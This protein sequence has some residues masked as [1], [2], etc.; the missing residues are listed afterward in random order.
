MKTRLRAYSRLALLL[1]MLF[2]SLFSYAQGNSQ[3]GKKEIPQVALEH[4]RN[5]KQKLN[6]NDEDISD[7]EL[8]SET[9]SKKSGVKHYYIK[10]LY[11]GVEIYGAIT[12]LSINREGSVI[13][14][15]NR[16]HKE[17]GKK[18]KGD[19]PGLDAAGAVA[20]AARY[21][22][23]SV[24]GSLTVL[25]RGKGRN[26]EVTFSKAGISLEPIAARLV[27]QPM[28]DGSLRLAWEVSI[29]ELDALNW[30]NLRLDATTGEVLDKD[31]MVVH[32]QFENNGPGGKFLH[33][34]HDHTLIPPYVAAPQAVPAMMAT[35][36]AY[37]VYAMPLESPSHGSRSLVSTSAAD[38][39]ASP[40]GWH[41]SPEGT[42]TTTRGNNVFAYEDPDNN[43]NYTINYSPDGGA[44]FNFDF[45]IDFTKQP[46]TYRDA[47][48]SNLFYW[49]NMVHDVWYQY[50]FDEMSGNFQYDI[51]GRGGKGNDPVL[52]E[53]Q[54]S[55]NIPLP[56]PGVTTRNNAN[57]STPRDGFVPRMQMY[58]WDGIPDPDLFSV[59]APA[60]IAGSYVAVQAAFGPRLTSTPV[61]GKL[62]V[63][64]AG[65]GNPAEGCS[66]YSNA[67][68]IAGNIAVIYRGSCEFGVKV[69]NAQNAG[70]IAAIV[71]NNQPGAS[72]MGVGATTTP[73]T[74]SSVM[75]SPETGAKLVEQL[76]NGVE[77]L[78]KLKDDGSGPEFDGDLDNG[79]IV[80]E[81]GHGIS[82]R[83]T[84]GPDVTGCLASA[85][86]I[87]NVVV[88]TEQM[89]EGWSDWFGLMMTMRQ[90]DTREKVR[91]IGTY[92]SAQPTTGNGIRPA[93][94]STSFG[95]N[96]FTYAATNNP[97][98]SAPHGVGFVWATMLWDMT[99]DLIDKY[100]YDP[101]LYNGTGG[102]NM[103]MQLV[104]DGLKLQPCRPGFV[105]GRNAILLA[106]RMNNEGANQELIWKAF[107][108]RGLGF[109]ASQGSNLRRDDQV[110]AFDLPATYAC[111]IPLNVAAVQSSTIYT[112]GVANNLYIGYGPK[113]VVLQASGDATNTYS[114]SPATG[115]SNAKI[116]NPVFTPTAA[117]TYTFTVTATNADQCIKT[118]TITIN[119][120]DVRCGDNKKRDK[121]LVCVDG[122]NNCAD[123]KAVNMMLTKAGGKLGDCNLNISAPVTA[124]TVSELAVAETDDFVQ[125]YPN[126]FSESTTIVFKAKETGYTVL[127]VYDITGREIETLFEGNAERG[128]TY[129]HSFKAGDKRA[130]IYIYKIVN[131]NTSRSG[132]MVLIK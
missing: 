99:W 39:K 35:S 18:V 69:L 16:F 101:D 88:S 104:I 117:G 9:D 6:V 121:V 3:A 2:G 102:N 72:S 107:A 63:A 29:Y 127:K 128:V 22:G 91:G 124:T 115:L 67:A 118:K 43:N 37:N 57:F 78:V 84:G 38:A 114:W 50:G 14:V 42:F 41:H 79:I 64:Q 125:S 77:V 1:A 75:V 83:L 46:V 52:A 80:H 11:Q 21:L 10:Q 74:I 93:P 15:G 60:T 86:L 5:N 23:L 19:Q 68:A 95:V 90:G 53:A 56:P 73:I 20:A 54:D 27:Y 96:N 34:E 30:W 89:G 85:V 129:N 82:N 25:E 59:T 44:S 126:P 105:D 113:S 132:T 33:D 119:V 98:I 122:E 7:L 24:K 49:N 100:G 130:G 47:A 26:K 92:V 31:N 110:Q 87:N 81:Y 112:G 71:I 94:Y 4:I 123:S 28:P 36:N 116:A 111:T 76:N 109:S 17:I 103:A 131:G 65:T 32:C 108:K 70:A 13:N 40:K 97:A 58:L 106:D 12:N 8:S 45:P 120:V 66:A 62:V 48:T 61:T 55:R 51:F